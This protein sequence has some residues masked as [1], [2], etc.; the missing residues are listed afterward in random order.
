MSLEEF[1]YQDSSIIDGFLELAQG[2]VY[3]VLPWVPVFLLVNT[4]FVYVA[5]YFKPRSIIRPC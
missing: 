3:N 4:I 5:S 2:T 1:L